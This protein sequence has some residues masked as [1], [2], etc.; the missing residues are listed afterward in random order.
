MSMVQ[1]QHG[2]VVPCL[3]TFTQ[4]PCQGM[5]W[6]E[7]MSWYPIEGQSTVGAKGHGQ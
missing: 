1:H 4:G 7:V 5:D 6:R 3:D 2:G